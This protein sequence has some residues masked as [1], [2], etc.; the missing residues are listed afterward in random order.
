MSLRYKILAAVIGINVV[1]LFATFATVFLETLTRVRQDRDHKRSLLGAIE[2]WAV[3]VSSITT[4]LGS[5]ALTRRL[6]IS[7]TPIILP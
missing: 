7:S 5:K 2:T 3:R 6:R 1:I 4:S